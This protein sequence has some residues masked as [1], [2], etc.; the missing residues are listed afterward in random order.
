MK[1]YKNILF[2][3]IGIALYSCGSQVQTIRPNKADLSKYDSYAYLPNASIKIDELAEKN[4]E[5]NGFLIETINDQMKKAGYSL[6]RDKPDL[7]VL[8]SVSTDLERESTQEPVY[9][10]YPYVNTVATTPVYPNYQSYYYRGFYDWYYPGGVIGYTT[11][12]YSYKEG[13]VVIDLVDRETKQSVWKGRTSESI[14]GGSDFQ[15]IRESILDIF[16]EY[17]LIEK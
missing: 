15:V 14:V 3:I 4:D 1:F 7:L 2:L 11:D 13:T 12:T 9:A 17:P 8:V 6:D 10:T 16:R 5:I